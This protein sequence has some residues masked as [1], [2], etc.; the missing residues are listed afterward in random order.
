MRQDSSFSRK[1]A[2]CDTFSKHRR[3]GGMNV[4]RSGWRGAAGDRL[5]ANLRRR[6]DVPMTLDP[7]V[8]ASRA[9]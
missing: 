2:R 5:R 7:P 3:T 1:V 9:G 6:R 4:A 8:M